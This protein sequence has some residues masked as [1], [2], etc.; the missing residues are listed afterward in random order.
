MQCLIMSHMVR[1]KRCT[2][3]VKQTFELMPKKANKDSIWLLVDG[4]AQDRE[5]KRCASSIPLKAKVLEMTC[6]Y[7]EFSVDLLDKFESFLWNSLRKRVPRI[8]FN[9]FVA[10]IE[11]DDSAKAPKKKNQNIQNR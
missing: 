8:L 5:S 10:Q 11:R 1:W 9:F 3:W 7:D 4:I 2:H 6:A